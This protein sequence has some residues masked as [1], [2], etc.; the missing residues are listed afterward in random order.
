MVQEDCFLAQ[1]KTFIR[2]PKKTRNGTWAKGGFFQTLSE[3]IL[4]LFSS[5]TSLA[6]W[7]Y[8]VELWTRLTSRRRQFSHWFCSAFLVFR[9]MRF[10]T[11]SA[12]TYHPKHTHKGSKFL[13]IW[14][15][16]CFL[17]Q[18]LGSPVILLLWCYSYFFLSFLLVLELS[19]Y[20]LICLDMRVD[21]TR[22]SSQ[23]PVSDLGEWRHVCHFYWWQKMSSVTFVTFLRRMWRSRTRN[24]FF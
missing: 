15:I 9:K 13:A 23:L 3:K 7:G 16:R 4:R 11:E 19:F 1:I 8:F 20:F 14:F 10:R 24:F 2:R 18:Q 22:S 17:N 6:R 5:P 21:L 12:K